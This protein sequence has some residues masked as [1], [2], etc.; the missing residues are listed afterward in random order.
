MVEPTRK[1]K[2]G[3]VEV[4]KWENKSKNSKGEEYTQVSFSFNKSYKDK[5]GELQQTQSF[6]TQDLPKLIVALQNA[7]E[8]AIGLFK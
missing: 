4:A 2:L 1:T 3:N 8:E 7:H 5:N 6:H